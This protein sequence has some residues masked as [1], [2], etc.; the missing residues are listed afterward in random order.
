MHAFRLPALIAWAGLAL[1]LATGIAARRPGG[2]LQLIALVNLGST[3][4]VLAYWGARWF[5]TLTRGTQWY[6]SDQ[7]M[8]AYAALIAMAAA[9][10]LTGRAQLTWLHWLAF[11][12][13]AIVLLLAALYLSFARF[14]RLT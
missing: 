13:H 6:L 14:G 5:G 2:G 7:A 4:C 8:P 10:T 11:V 12:L 9:L 1:H 3:L